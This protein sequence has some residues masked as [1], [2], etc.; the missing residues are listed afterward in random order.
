MDFEPNVDG[1]TT[2]KLSVVLECNPDITNPLG[3]T[4][5]VTNFDTTAG[6]GLGVTAGHI[7]VQVTGASAYGIFCS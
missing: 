3:T 5:T 4:F 7:N 2:Y 1:D 6:A